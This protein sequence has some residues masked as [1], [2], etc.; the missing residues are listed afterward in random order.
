MDFKTLREHMVTEQLIPRGISNVRVL[1]AFRKVKRHKFVPSKMSDIAY[2]DHPIPI[3]V[4]QTISQPFMVALM[5]EKLKLNGT[6]KVLEIGTGSG[7]QASILA[8]L[9]KEVCTIERHKELS[10]MA[11]ERLLFLGY[12]NVKF[13][14]GDG[15]QGWNDEAPFD[16]IIVTAGSP[17]VPDKL[18]SQ[19]KENGRMVIPLGGS[20]SQTLTLITKNRDKIATEEI[21]ACVFVPLIGEGAWKKE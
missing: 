12:N 11:K 21:C 17:K 16:A 15:S 19:L 8:E 6:E 5:T 18:I 2:S 13:S 9:A 20:L 4:G 14:T 7:Y 3:G 1:E 10:D